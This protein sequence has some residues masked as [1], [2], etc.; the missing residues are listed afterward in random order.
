MNIWENYNFTEKNN[1]ILEDLNSQ[2]SN[3]QEITN[4]ILEQSIESCVNNN[5][6]I[7]YR[8]YI[9]SSNLG[10]YRIKILTVI[11]KKKNILIQSNI[12]D[13]KTYEDYYN[14]SSFLKSIESVINETLCATR[15]SNLYQQI[16]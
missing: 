8:L 9:V 2:K 15:I 13:T 14:T 10:N 7:E 3:L 12:T 11:A 5:G 6:K 16:L 4:G 1:S